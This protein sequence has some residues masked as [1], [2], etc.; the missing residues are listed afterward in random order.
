MNADK[1]GWSSKP[2][3]LVFTVSLFGFICVYLRVSA[4]QMV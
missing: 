3:R 1:R 2:K 4:A